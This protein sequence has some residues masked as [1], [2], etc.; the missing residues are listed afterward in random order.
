MNQS[1]QLY[2]TTLQ[3]SPSATTEI[4]DH[5]PRKMNGMEYINE[6]GEEKR[7]KE[8]E[9]ES[10]K[11]NERKRNLAEEKTIQDGPQEKSSATI[12]TVIMENNHA[13]KII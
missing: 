10:R 11:R 6:G 13:R 2:F 9:S 7:R 5:T 1:I 4:D 12:S 8:G 3:L